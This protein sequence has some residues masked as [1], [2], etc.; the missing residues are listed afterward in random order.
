MLGGIL[1]AFWRFLEI[2]TLIPVIGMLSYFVSLYNSANA[3]TPDA[4]LVLFIVSILACVWAI[5]TLFTWHR[6]RTNGLFVAFIDLCFVGAFIGAVWALRGIQHDSCSSLTDVS[7]S[8]SFGV[9]GSV[10]LGGLGVSV[11]KTCALLKASWALGIMNCVMFFFTAVL[12]WLV[13]GRKR[14]R[15]EV[16]VRRET[17]YSRHG[18]SR[19]SGS[20]RSGG[21]RRSEYSQSGRRRAYV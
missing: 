1:F 11:D 17:H 21:S 16:V 5:A 18:G 14:D 4:I 20:H 6:T 7:Y 9:L 8:A 13:S 19:R 12:S 15:E 3:L 2:L 10:T